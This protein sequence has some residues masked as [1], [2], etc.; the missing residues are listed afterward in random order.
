RDR[1][2][3]LGFVS[4][5]LRSDPTGWLDRQR[6]RGHPQ[7]LGLLA[8]PPR[9]WGTRLWIG[10]LLWLSARAGGRGNRHRG[11]G[12]YSRRR[13]LLAGGSRRRGVRL[14]RRQLPWLDGRTA[15]E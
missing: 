14:R 7:R 1:G 15:L 13:W 2:G 3:D 11:H 10:R 12:W 8:G 4:G 6:V 5:G 9:R